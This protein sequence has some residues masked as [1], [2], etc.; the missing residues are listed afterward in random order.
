MSELIAPENTMTDAP[1]ATDMQLVCC[2]ACG[3][4]APEPALEANAFRQDKSERFSIVRCKKCGHLY[5]SPR[6]K[7]EVLG[8]YYPDTYYDNLEQRQAGKTNQGLRESVLRWA[9]RHHM[10]YP[11][12]KTLGWLG[13]LITWPVSRR[14]RY[15]RRH[16]ET[17]IWA[18]EGKLLDF[19]CGGC[20]FLAMQRERGWDARGIDFSETVAK[21]AGEVYGLDVT[22]GT[23]PGDALAEERFDV[24][25]G[26]HLIEHVPNPVGWIKQAAEQLKPGGYM[27]LCCPDIDSWAFRTFGRYW[28]GLDLPRH[29]SHFSKQKLASLL[30]DAGLVVERV[31]AQNRPATLRGSARN[32]GE[33]TGSAYWKMIA[34][35]KRIWVPIAWWTAWAR[36]ADGQVIIARKPKA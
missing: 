11:G 26:W 25:T 5:T 34:R 10:G 24:I 30:T 27:L 17:L 23:W 4:D 29:L 8:R 14:M 12:R 1:Q 36:S 22:V 6:P 16:V 19:G 31:R 21:R 15:S 9:M 3:A 20:R 2:T 13:W 7:L 33:Q 32:R 18:G 28:Y 35:M